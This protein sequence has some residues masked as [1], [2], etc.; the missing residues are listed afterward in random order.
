MLTLFSFI[1]L[2]LSITREHM[3]ILNDMH[4]DF[5]KCVAFMDA[6]ASHSKLMAFVC[7]ACVQSDR[8]CD[9]ADGA[10]AE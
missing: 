5:D 9:G 8:V 6:C 2:G 4:A 10:H 1:R 3:K 7:G